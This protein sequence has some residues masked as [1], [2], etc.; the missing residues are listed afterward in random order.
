VNKDVLVRVV[1]ENICNT[2]RNRNL[3]LF[4]VYRLSSIQT[5]L[6]RPWVIAPGDNPSDFSRED[7]FQHPVVT[8][9]S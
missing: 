1:K 6:E 7:I 8:Q 4:I 2:I 3:E 5:A 9:T